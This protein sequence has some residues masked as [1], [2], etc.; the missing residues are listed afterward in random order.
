MNCNRFAGKVKG[1]WRDKATAFVFAGL[2]VLWLTG[3]L[4]G[5]V[6]LPGISSAQQPQRLTLVAWEHEDGPDLRKCVGMLGEFSRQYPHLKIDMTHDDWANAY[7]RI[8]RWCGS[9]KEHA[10]D[11]TVIPDE[12]LAQF[13]PNLCTFGTSFGRYLEPFIPAVPASATLDDRI[14]GAPWRMDAYALYYRPDLLPDGRSAP[15]T[16]DEL[17]TT[18]AEVAKPQQGLYGLGLP[19]AVNGGGARTLLILLWGAGGSLYDEQGKIDFTSAQMTAALEYWVRL[20]RGG[21]LQPEVLSWDTGQLQRAFA[22]RKLGMVLAGSA[23]ANRLRTEHGALNFAIAPLPYRDQP[24]ASI[25]ATYVVIMRTTQHRAECMEFLKF[26]ALRTAQDWMWQT[27]SVP[28]HREVI[29]QVGGEPLMH[30][31][32]ANLEHARVRPQRDWKNLE[33]MLDDALFLAVSGRCSPAEALATMQE[34]YITASLPV[35]P[36]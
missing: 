10:P 11:M 35:P 25:A 4:A 30:A 19:G 24:V 5:L 18:A 26:M 33:A 6:A 23:F 29:S 1:L 20:A 28:S 7:P 2:Q 14:Y 15:T 34:R 9:L 22:E 16:W 8:S 21:A 32:L 12:W 36:Q 27:G 17:L 13:A 3:C 31:F